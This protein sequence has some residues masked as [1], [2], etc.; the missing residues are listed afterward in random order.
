MR[1]FR[2]I[3]LFPICGVVLTYIYIFSS[4][5]I[6]KNV[7]ILSYDPKTIGAQW[8]YEIALYFF[9]LSIFSIPFGILALIALIT[10]K[11]YYGFN[12]FLMVSFVTG[13]VFSLLLNYFDP[14]N[15]LFWFFD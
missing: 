11:K 1:I 14:G 6:L 3:L 10:K 13:I 9:G 12:L 5:I 2:I 8:F 4:M 15:Y 7:D